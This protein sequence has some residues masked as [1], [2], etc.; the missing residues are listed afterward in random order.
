M[1]EFDNHRAAAMA[2]LTRAALKPKEGGFLGQ[3]AFSDEPLTPRQRI[4]LDGL[5]RR[6][7]LP[8]LDDGGAPL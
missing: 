7:S 5:L 4:W 2:L 6:H 8:P 1:S 3:V